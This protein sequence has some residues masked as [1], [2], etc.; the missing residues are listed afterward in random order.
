MTTKEYEALKREETKQK[1]FSEYGKIFAEMKALLVRIEEQEGDDRKYLNL[2]KNDLV[3]QIRNLGR[4]ALNV[5]ELPDPEENEEEF[6]F[7][8]EDYEDFF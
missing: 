2:L 3:E 6:P 1:H 4:I 7:L 8:E 5:E